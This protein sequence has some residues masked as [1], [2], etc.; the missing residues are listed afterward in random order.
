[1][2]HILKW[3]V[4]WRATTVQNT[5]K[6]YTTWQTTRLNW[7]LIHTNG[8]FYH[9]HAKLICSCIAPLTNTSKAAAACQTNLTCGH[10]RLARQYPPKASLFYTHLS[11]IAPL[12][13]TSKAAASS[14][15]N[16]TCGHCWLARQ[17]P[18]KASLFYT[19]LSCIAPLTNA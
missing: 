10:Y 17:Y 13:S 3:V 7:Q 18:P 11:C 4:G 5:T 2:M 19:H 1:M 6:D 9:T 15:T 16:L 14:R 12:T 8:G